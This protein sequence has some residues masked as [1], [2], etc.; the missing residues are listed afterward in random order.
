[1]RA[2][3][4]AV[5]PLLLALGSGRAAAQGSVFGLRGLGWLGRG[6]SARSAGTEGALS[7]F[8]PQM[9]ANPAA[10]G[11]WRSA[12][13]W[14][15]VAPTR[16]SF[17][18]PSG[19]ASLQ[20][21]RFPVFG[22]AAVIPTRTVVSVAIS[23]YLD[24]TWTITRQDSTVLRGVTEKYTEAGRSIGGV[25]DMSL[26]AAYRLTPDLMVGVG[27]HHYLGSARLA[28]QK[29]FDNVVYQ[30]AAEASVTDFSGAGIS[31]GVLGTLQ[32]LDVAFAARLNGS[33]HSTN[34]SGQSA[35]TKLPNQLGL[36]LRYLPVPGVFLVGSAEYAGWGAA[37]ADL[38]AAA[39]D[40]ARNTWSLAAG[41]EVLSVS[42]LGLRTPLRIGYRWR[43]LPFLSLGQGIDESAFGGGFGFSLARGRTSVDFSFEKGSR[44]TG[45]EQ[46]TFSTIFAGLT[47]RP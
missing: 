5:L 25:S 9:T 30:Q 36:G 29:L 39:R 40:G 4:A 45:A 35:T 10:L 46:E 44:S 7:L 41:A 28:A 31:V 16:R 12:A 2:R 13:G 47:V 37:N 14:A 33:L 22:F 23:D 21:S 38:L 6:V 20:T 19:S 17:E 26:S 1:M 15:V 34:T 8:D 24:R 3:V 42:L 11:H 43:Q 27:F 18:G 32:H